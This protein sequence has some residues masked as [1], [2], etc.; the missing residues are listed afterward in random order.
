M[1]EGGLQHPKVIPEL[2][3]TQG[4]SYYK[5]KLIFSL[6]LYKIKIIRI[7]IFEGVSLE[8]QIS[9]GTTLRP[10]NIFINNK[11]KIKKTYI[12]NIFKYSSSRIQISTIASGRW[13]E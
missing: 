12:P 9:G 13:S 5:K 7:F 11:V 10:L 2:I 3:P 6:L 1:N 4:G 8:V